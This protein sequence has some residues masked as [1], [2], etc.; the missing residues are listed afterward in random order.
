MSWV[1]HRHHHGCL[2]DEVAPSFRRGRVDV[3]DPSRGRPDVSPTGSP[4]LLPL[5]P[6]NGIPFTR[7]Q[8]GGDFSDKLP[9]FALV[10]SL[11]DDV[12]VSAIY[13]HAPLRGPTAPPPFDGAAA[14]LA[15]IIN[16][17]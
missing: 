15:G 12:R 10:A 4:A 2:A 1:V 13:V 11:A 7:F 5:L 16:R 3:S 9:F 17:R 14:R 6:K 8:R